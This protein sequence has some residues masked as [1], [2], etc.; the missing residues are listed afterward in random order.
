[1]RALADRARGQR[2]HRHRQCATMCY[3]STPRSLAI[4]RRAM[5]SAVCARTSRDDCQRR[6]PPRQE[7]SA[8]GQHTVE[9]GVGEERRPGEGRVHLVEGLERRAG[10]LHA[11]DRLHPGGGALGVVGAGVERDLRVAKDGLARARARRPCRQRTGTRHPEA[12]DDLG[13]A[14]LAEGVDVVKRTD[15]LGRQGAVDLELL[16]ENDDLVRDQGREVGLVEAAER[17]GLG[18]LGPGSGEI[19]GLRR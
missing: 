1:M 3:R 14:G 16:E 19:V 9:A 12:P 18:G 2:R 7:Q 11:A 4:M 8:R 17:R 5:G 6:R 15:R 13:V 10:K